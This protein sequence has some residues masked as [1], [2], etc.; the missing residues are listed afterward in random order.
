MSTVLE[1]WRNTLDKVPAEVKPYFQFQDN[2]TAQNG[3]LFKGEHLIVSTKLRKEWW[4][5]SVCP[6]LISRVVFDEQPGMNAEFKIPSHQG[7]GK[8]SVR[9]SSYLTSATTWSL[10]STTLLSLRWVSSIRQ[11]PE[12]L[13]RSWKCSLG[14]TEFRRSI[15][16]MDCNML[17]QSL[18]SL[19]VLAL[20]K[21]Y[22]LSTESTKLQK[23][24]VKVSEN[25]M[26]KEVHAKFDPY[27]TLRKLVHPQCK[28]CSAGEDTISYHCQVNN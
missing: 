12:L 20:S 1:G 24:W 9:I 2:I 26:R 10:W 8:R 25:I 15:L 4:K 14:N 3:L 22:Y 6:I 7:L 17:L 18:Q 27:L 21:Y 28:S 11:I 19:Q 13:L 5:R 16:T 23:G